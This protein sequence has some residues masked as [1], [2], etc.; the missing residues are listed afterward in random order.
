M[1]N[2]IKEGTIAVIAIGDSQVFYNLYA[3]TSALKIPYLSIK[4]DSLEDKNSMVSLTSSLNKKKNEVIVMK[5]SD[6]NAIMTNSEEKDK[7]FSN[8]ITHINMYPPAHKLM[9]AVLD[10]IMYYNWDYVTILF[11]EFDSLYRIE[12]LIRLQTKARN[13]KLRFNVKQLGS[14]VTKWID[15]LKEIK[16]SGSSHIVV[17]I[18]SRHLN[19]F[20][21]M[22]LFS[23]NLN[24]II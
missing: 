7:H 18:Q 17:D 21:E 3:I 15:V 16:L 19:K 8:E 10:L 11:Q 9:K 4:W 24:S 12:D 6:S 14:N 22:V 2:E 20:F 5:S 23:I 13:E 1:C